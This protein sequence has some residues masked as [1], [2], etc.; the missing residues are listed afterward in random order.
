MESLRQ[1][2]HRPIK[3]VAKELGLSL[4]CFKKECRRLGVP[5]WPARKLGCLARMR[6]TLMRDGRASQ[7]SKQELLEL[8][9]RN[10]DEIVNDPNAPMYDTFTRVR[11]EQYKARGDG[12]A[13][14][15]ARR[16]AAGRGGADDDVEEED[17]DE[18]VEDEEDGEVGEM[19][20]GNGA[21]GR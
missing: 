7:K 14:G 18:E 4:S 21:G 1:H 20:K 15:R 10:M 19:D 12:R 6:D 16:H 9:Q 17:S 3:A 5:R 13:G 8:M 11:H 2:Y